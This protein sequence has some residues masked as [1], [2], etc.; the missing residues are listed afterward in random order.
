MSLR[1]ERAIIPLMAEHSAVRL[2]SVDW[3]YF[4]NDPVRGPL[5][6]AGFLDFMSVDTE[7][8]AWFQ[9]GQRAID[10]G[11][12]AQMTSGEETGFWDRFSFSPCWSW[13][14]RAFAKDR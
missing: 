8:E 3:D 12:G 11:N 13:S 6:Y 2:L 14:R 1:L 10:A 7:S 4:V 9:R 5:I